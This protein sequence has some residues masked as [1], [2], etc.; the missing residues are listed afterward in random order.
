MS[1]LSPEL[2][3]PAAGIRTSAEFLRGLRAALPVM[4]G[5]I[6]FALVLGAQAVA[7][8]FST[9]EVPLLTGLN[10]GGGSEFA[11][12]DLWTS[13]P[14]LLLIAAVTLLVN[15]RYFLMGATFA[16]RI[17]AVP[18]R[19]ALALLFFMC[20]ESW[21]MGIADADANANANAGAS[22][23]TN[24]RA[25]D[26]DA[27]ER[28]I[29]LGYYMGVSLGLYLTWVTGTTAGALLGPVIG[30]VRAYGFDMAFPA[31][32]IVM[33]AGMWKGAKPARPWGV[34]LVTAGM[35]Y[36]LVPGAWY[37]PA[38]IIAGLTAAT[39]MAKPARPMAEPAP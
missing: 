2:P 35:V 1:E 18:K 7:K 34:S 10:F 25:T 6:P 17:R 33:L 29:S 22:R 8:G 16:L 19:R 20:D 3:L 28:P 32:F 9:V 27:R 5:F 21:A 39:L 38:G 23:G 13:P 24:P 11:A 12:I 15:S 26:V 36:H 4:L 31:V 14:H 30:D 37:V